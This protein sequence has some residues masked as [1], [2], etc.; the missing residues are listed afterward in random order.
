VGPD[1]NSA[2]IPAS[3]RVVLRS[4]THF[5][6]SVT[7]TKESVQELFQQYQQFFRNA[8]DGDVDLEQGA[9]F[10]ATAVIGAAPAGVMVAQN[11]EKFWLSMRQDFEAYRKMG[12]KDMRIRGIDVTPIDEL[13]CLARVGWTA[14]Y[15]RGDA[16]DISIDFDVHYLVQQVQGTPKIFGWISGDEQAA[17]EEHGII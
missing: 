6:H 2:L 1:A 12:T 5:C 10:Y 15:D 13:H 17:L 4:S 7:M 9:S 14:V 8:I 11:D 3:N 16:P